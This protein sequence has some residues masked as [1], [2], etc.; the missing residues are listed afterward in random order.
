M[1]TFSAA[2]AK[3]R[4]GQMLEACQKGPVAIEKHGRR[5]AVV[6]SGEAYD[7]ARLH[8]AEALKAMIDAGLADADAGRVR[9]AEAVF[10]EL[11]ADLEEDSAA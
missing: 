6:M 11:L 7:F 8:Q 2:D 9:D 10:A 5:V 4:F 1:D 3:N